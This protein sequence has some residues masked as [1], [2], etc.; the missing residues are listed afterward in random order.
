MTNP[1]ERIPSEAIGTMHAHKDLYV[2]AEYCLACG[3]VPLYKGHDCNGGKGP[4]TDPCPRC[5]MIPAHRE[6]RFFC[7]WCPFCEGCCADLYRES[8]F[9]EG[10]D[11]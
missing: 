5:G 2:L 1:A 8:L 3:Q 6:H 11:A 9:K 4:V 7:K 10:K